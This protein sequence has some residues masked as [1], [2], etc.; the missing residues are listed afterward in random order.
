[1]KIFYGLKSVTKFENKA[2]LT[3]FFAHISP[4]YQEVWVEC[5]INGVFVE[6]T[7]HIKYSNSVTR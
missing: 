7:H 5:T 4:K 2:E 6:P 1:M 3:N